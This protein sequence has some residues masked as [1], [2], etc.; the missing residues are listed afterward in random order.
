[1][2][3]KAPGTPGAHFPCPH[4]PVWSHHPGPFASHRPTPQTVL[5]GWCLW[6]EAVNRWTWGLRGDGCG[7]L[8]V[9]SGLRGGSAGGVNLLWSCGSGLVS[10]GPSSSPMGRSL[11][12]AGWP[13]PEAGAAGVPRGRTFPGGTH[14]CLLLAWLHCSCDNRCLS[15]GPP[16]LSVPRASG[17]AGLL[18]DGSSQSR[19]AQDSLRQGP[20]HPSWAEGACRS[21]Q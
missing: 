4:I 5:S 19:L 18:L 12:R 1:M 21:A 14:V 17:R 9:I 8:R 6:Q 2:R 15:G 11:L 13:W 20:G 3:G 7:S 10:V 16:A